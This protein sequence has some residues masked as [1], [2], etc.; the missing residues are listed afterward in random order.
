MYEIWNI[1]SG[2]YSEKSFFHQVNLGL[3]YERLTLCQNAV[4]LLVTCGSQ[5]FCNLGKSFQMSFF[6]ASLSGM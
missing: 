5:L 6:R 3:F 2:R 4:G 1:A